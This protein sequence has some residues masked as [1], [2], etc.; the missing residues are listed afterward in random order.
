ML[1]D[2]F[3]IMQ[4][5]RRSIAARC[6]ACTIFK[7]YTLYSIHCGY[8]RN[9]FITRH[10]SLLFIS[11]CNVLTHEDPK[12]FARISK[13]MAHQTRNVHPWAFVC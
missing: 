11:S 13:L 10:S 8:T 5:M 9:L 4:C 7:L 6:W 3:G 12:R 1:Y 2:S